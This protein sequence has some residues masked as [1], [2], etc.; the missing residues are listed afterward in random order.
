MK[1]QALAFSRVSGRSMGTRGRTR[2]RE[3]E[4]TWKKVAL[5]K[6]TNLQQLQHV[7][8]LQYHYIV[9][10]LVDDI[11]DARSVEKQA[12]LRKA[13]PTPQKLTK[14]EKPTIFH[15]FS[16]NFVSEGGN[17]FI[18]DFVEHVIILLAKKHFKVGESK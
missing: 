13:S 17:L 12:A 6:Y 5:L 7:D 11:K 10:L 14:P 3:S 18:W 9:I 4:K 16:T 1:W 8:L 15:R 2:K